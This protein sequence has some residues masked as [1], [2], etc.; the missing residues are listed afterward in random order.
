MTASEIQSTKPAPLCCLSMH[1]QAWRGVSQGILS[2]QDAQRAIDAGVDGIIVSNHGGR[3]VDFAPA[4]LD[5]LAAVASVVNG[6]VPLLVDGGIRRG[7]DI[8][9]VRIRLALLSA[10]QCQT[11]QAL[12]EH[13]QCR[14]NI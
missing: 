12:R 3:Q 14:E 8:I 5:M 7:T 9:K 1:R 13:L 4:P 6:R 11:M 2:P 10:L